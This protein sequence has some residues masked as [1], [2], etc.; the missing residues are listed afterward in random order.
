MA[1][2][3]ALGIDNFGSGLF[4]PLTLVFVTQVV[5]LPLATAGSAVTLGTLAGLAVPPLAGR[6]VDRVGARTVVITAQLLQGA[7]AVSYLAAHGVV[8]VVLA[9]M[10]LAAGQQMFYSALFALIADV[11]DVGP[12]DRAF[13]VANMV[14]GATFGLGALVV[15]GLLTGVGPVGYQLAIGIDAASFVLAASMLAFWLHIPPPT[16]A[17]GDH[18]G[19]SAPATATT[20]VLR[21]RPY[22]GLIAITTMFALATDFFLIGVPVY[23]LDV[24]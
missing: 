21:N 17:T 1:L 23:A 12:K 9:A 8:L 5:G 20:G 10:L 22:L 19:E 18:A 4:L 15:G 14:R 11:A 24:L 16:P 3:V 13:V 2:L 7:G 6:L